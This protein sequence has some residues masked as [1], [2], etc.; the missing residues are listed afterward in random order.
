MTRSKDPKLM[1]LPKNFQE[2]IEQRE[3]INEEKNKEEETE[4]SSTGTSKDNDLVNHPKH[5]NAHPSGIECIQIA[6]HYQCNI[7]NA[8]K[9]L[10]R[11]GLKNGESSIK[12]LQKAI[13]YIVDEIQLQGGK[14]EDIK[15]ERHSGFEE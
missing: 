14:V 5:Y 3:M 9:Y 11:Q 10:W 4:G 13:W 12:D 6:R 2:I 7:A 1:P 15:I 8:I